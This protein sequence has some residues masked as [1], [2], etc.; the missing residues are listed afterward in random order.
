MVEKNLKHLE[1][2]PKCASYM[3]SQA[4]IEQGA[5]S[6]DWK[7]ET[8]H[9]SFGGVE[10]RKFV[11]EKCHHVEIYQIDDLVGIGEDD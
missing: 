8:F 7:D 2:C 5:T 6:R 1:I 4:H 3:R 10:V 9:R 11:C